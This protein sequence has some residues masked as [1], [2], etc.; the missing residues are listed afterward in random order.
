M[1]LRLSAP[2]ARGSLASMDKRSLASFAIICAFTLS[3]AATSKPRESGD[4]GGGG[5]GSAVAADKAFTA[6]NA[7]AGAPTPPAKCTDALLEATM[8]SVVTPES[9]AKPDKHQMPLVDQPVAARFSRANAKTNYP[10][11]GFWV[12]N[13]PLVRDLHPKS[14]DITEQSDSKVSS[15]V[16]QLGAH[17]LFALLRSETRTLPKVNANGDDFTGGTL[18]GKLVVA[19]MDTGAPVC[20]IGVTAQSSPSVKFKTRGITGKS[21]EKAIRDDFFEQLVAALKAAVKTAAPSFS[22]DVGT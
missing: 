3:L 22:V 4:G 1:A 6:I 13:A 19:R 11:D 7:V 16:T 18:S 14:W 2:F 8:K 12:I 17:P 5:G 21:F 15:N 9:W 10:D 20:V